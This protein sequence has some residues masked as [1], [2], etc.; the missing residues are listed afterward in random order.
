MTTYFDHSTS[1]R[2][3][4]PNYPNLYR[5]HLTIID[6][7]LAHNLLPNNSSEPPSTNSSTTSDS[8]LSQLDFN[9]KTDVVCLQINLQ[10]SRTATAELT[11][12]LSSLN[13]FITFIQEP[14]QSRKKLHGIPSIIKQHYKPDDH[15]RSAICHSA[16]LNIFKVNHLCDRD[17]TT[18]LWQP[19]S[20][21][22]NILLVSVY[23]D[24]NSHTLPALL[25]LAIEFAQHHSYEILLSL[26]SN[27][28]STLW[29]C[30][31]D[32]AR[33][34]TFEQFLYRYNLNLLNTGTTST[35]YSIRNPQ[36]TAQSII[37]L[38]LA[39]PALTLHVQSWKV[40]ETWSASDH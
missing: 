34:T 3:L 13:T 9:T 38:S 30:P 29:G 8:V 4:I 23:W 31:R 1:A 16:N 27:A 20:E 39:T 11:K 36:T 6:I 35:Y 15:I 33:G 10:H 37:D 24:S 25:P 40:H 7:L 26:D 21:R 18:C 19:G 22:D 28:H 5:Q 32:D 12:R 14:W 17:V 2:I